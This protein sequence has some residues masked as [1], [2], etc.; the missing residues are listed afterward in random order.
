MLFLFYV[1]LFWT[2]LADATENSKPTI[3]ILGYIH[4]PRQVHS[5]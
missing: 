4:C 1:F 3:K 2:Q 5:F